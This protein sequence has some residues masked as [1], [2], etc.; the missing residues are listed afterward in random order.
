MSSVS[1]STTTVDQQQLANSP[2]IVT[3]TIPAIN[4]FASSS[5]VTRTTSPIIRNNVDISLVRK[6]GLDESVADSMSLS[7]KKK[8]KRST[9]A[10]TVNHQPVQ[11]V[12]AGENLAFKLQMEQLK[13]AGRKNTSGGESVVRR[14]VI[15]DTPVSCV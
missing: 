7:N 15:G 8:K 9:S 2:S 5:A 10:T 1:N 13:C 14:L 3:S 4:L 12:V 6:L 11:H